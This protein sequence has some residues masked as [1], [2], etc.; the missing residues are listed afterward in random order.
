MARAAL[1][2]AALALCAGAALAA[3]ESDCSSIAGCKACTLVEPEKKPEKRQAVLMCTACLDSVAYV[4]TKRGKC[5]ECC[6]HGTGRG[7]GQALRIPL[8]ALAR[9]CNSS[10]QQW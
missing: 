4:L 1:L 3:M 7:E 10:L 9:G 2:L 6:N 5:G 8:S